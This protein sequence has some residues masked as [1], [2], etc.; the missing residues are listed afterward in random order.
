MDEGPG[1]NI[2]VILKGRNLEDVL[3]HYMTFFKRAAGV[4]EERGKP[5]EDA[6]ADT[7]MGAIYRTYLLGVEDGMKG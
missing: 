1:I 2:D 4:A 6:V 3:A 7:M 5:E